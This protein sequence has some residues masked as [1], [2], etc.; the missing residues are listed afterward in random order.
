MKNK[1]VFTVLC[2]DGGG[3]RGLIPARILE[4]IEKRTGKPISQLFDLGGAPSTGSI[5]LT[6][7]GIPDPENP[8]KPRYSARNLV[9]FYEK[10]L[11]KIFG[12]SL[13]DKL[14][15]L[16][17]TGGM[18]DPAPLDNALDTAFGDARLK[19]SL[20]DLII[21]VANIGTNKPVYLEHYKD[22][23][24][25]SREQWSTMRAAEA[26]RCSSSAPIF[27]P[28]KEAWTTPHPGEPPQA[29]HLI[30]G[31]LFA[32]NVPQDLMAQAKRLAPPDS[33]IVLVHIGTGLSNFSKTTTEFN[34][35]KLKTRFGEIMSL[36][37]GMS[38]TA[39]L[40]SLKE[41]MGNRLF[42][43]DE[44][45]TDAE[46]DDGRPETLAYLN[47]FADYVIE[48]N[49]D[50]IDRLC[51]ILTY[52]TMTP[53]QAYEG[54]SQFFHDI[55]AQMAQIDTVRD[56]LEFDTALKT[57]AQYQ[58]LPEHERAD[59][60]DIYTDLMHERLDAGKTGDAMR[61]MRNDMRKELATLFENMPLPGKDNR[62]NLHLPVYK[63]SNL[64]RFFTMLSKCTSK[65]ARAF[66]KSAPPKPAP[67][68]ERIQPATL[69]SL[70]TDASN[71]NANATSE[72]PQ[73]RKKRKNAPET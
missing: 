51:Q 43:F 14:L 17:S 57:D 64:S 21:P 12:G 50:L 68:Q 25:L 33:E 41:Q 62:N 34:N 38:S 32:G 72:K 35:T 53:K 29:H 56:L 30:D 10:Y 2:I 31:G 73:N 16:N 55:S 13:S 65:V 23:P 19:D 60:T 46:M 58:A 66:G 52:R 69:N 63:K 6:G 9:E 39:S 20:L 42:S 44:I 15:R 5:L 47:E 36:F 54:N 70:A 24:D 11:P 67:E 18:Y 49:S 26:V 22:V 48:K 1:R 7:L 61:E 59:L 8:G 40:R 27:F 45:L 71:D 4:E 28:A 37:I 3:A